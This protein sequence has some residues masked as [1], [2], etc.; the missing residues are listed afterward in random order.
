MQLSYFYFVSLF[1]KHSPMSKSTINRPKY[2]EKRVKSTITH[3]SNQTN[4][5]TSAA[6]SGTP[7]ERTPEKQ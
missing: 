5:A 3:T 2:F 1:P 4:H 7:Y 6:T